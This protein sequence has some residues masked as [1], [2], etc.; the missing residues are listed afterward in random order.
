MVAGV[1]SEGALGWALMME[2]PC[3]EGW[4]LPTSL[5]ERSMQPIFCGQ[6]GEMAPS[7]TVLFLFFF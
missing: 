4:L 2:T 3:F 5:P 7:H 1:H 6:C